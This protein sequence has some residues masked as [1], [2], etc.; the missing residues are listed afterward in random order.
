MINAVRDRFNTF[1]Q[2]RRADTNAAVPWVIMDDPRTCTGEQTEH[3]N[4]VAHRAYAQAQANT[5]YAPGPIS[6]SMDGSVSPH[7][8][9]M[10]LDGT[11]LMGE[12]MAH[13][14]MKAEGVSPTSAP[15]TF[16]QSATRGPNG[17]YVDLTFT[18]HPFG[19]SLVTG[20]GGSPQG[21]YY[22][23]TNINPSLLSVRDHNI[24]ITGPNTVRVSPK[25][26]SFPATTYWNY[27]AGGPRFG[28]EANPFTYTRVGGVGTVTFAQP[29]AIPLQV[30]DMMD[31]NFTGNDRL[32]S[33]DKAVVSIISSTQFTIASSEADN[34]A[35]T[36]TDPNLGATYFAR[37]KSYQDACCADMLFWNDGGYTARPGTGVT[38]SPNNVVA[39]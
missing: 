18:P 27:A 25:V 6:N 12:T 32:D 10:T 5:F 20:N 1:P 19:A 24:A 29:L 9:T 3:V 2:F 34:T 8:D 36:Y 38:F 14:L 11:A 22:A 4:R 7:G 15:V 16:L 37:A 13:G 30:G 26:G 28:G 39:S 31:M 35:F 23:T 21:I 17:A 33:G